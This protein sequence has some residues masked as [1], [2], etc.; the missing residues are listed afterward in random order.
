M[1]HR[2]VSG[3]R[4][5]F[6]YTGRSVFFTDL[7]KCFMTLLAGDLLRKCMCGSCYL[8]VVIWFK[9]KLWFTLLKLSTLCPK[10][11]KLSIPFDLADLVSHS[12]ISFWAKIMRKTLFLKNYDLLL[13]A[14]AN[15]PTRC[16]YYN[17]ER[18]F[19]NLH[20]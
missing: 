10:D 9:I 7:F 17:K 6:T 19:E 13:F 16:R 5:T 14:T 12:Q 3:R 11:Q 2:A 4:I 15:F 1:S 18:N 20:P 8:I